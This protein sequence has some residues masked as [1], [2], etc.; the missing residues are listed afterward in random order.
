MVKGTLFLWLNCAPTLQVANITN[1]TDTLNEM[2]NAIHRASPSATYLI[3]L[4]LQSTLRVFFFFSLFTFFSFLYFPLHFSF[5][6]IT[7]I[8]QSVGL[9][10][11]MC[12]PTFFIHLVVGLASLLDLH[13][14]ARRVL[15]T[16]KVN[17]TESISFLIFSPCVWETNYGSPVYCLMTYRVIQAKFKT[18]AWK[19]KWINKQMAKKAEIRLFVITNPNCIDTTSHKYGNQ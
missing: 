9:A 6:V 10:M 1:I 7:I 12:T 17:N 15:C 16:N 13:K 8:L 3:F 2:V 18:N 11:S 14:T 4:S 5:S 19:Q